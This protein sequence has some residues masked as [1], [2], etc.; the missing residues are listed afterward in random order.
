LFENAAAKSSHCF[1]EGQA[2]EIGR[3][4]LQG[5]QIKRGCHTGFAVEVCEGL[6]DAD[7]EFIGAGQA[8]VERCGLTGEFRRQVDGSGG[9]DD[10]PAGSAELFS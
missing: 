5:V 1:R 2:R 10:G 3:K 6:L 7:Q 8:K 9:D 4:P